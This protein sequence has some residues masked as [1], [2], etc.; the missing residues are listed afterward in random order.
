MP[1]HQRPQRIY[2]KTAPLVGIGTVERLSKSLKA[3]ARCL[4]ALLVLWVGISL[5]SPD[6][7]FYQVERALSYAGPL[8]AMSQHVRSFPETMSSIVQ[9]FFEARAVEV[10]GV[11]INLSRAVNPTFY[12]HDGKLTSQ[13]LQEERAYRVYLPPGY[14]DSDAHYPTLVLLHGMGQDHKWWTEVARIDRI[15]TAMITS[16]KMRPTIIVMPNGNR[17]EGDVATTGLY[18]GNCKT[19][20][21]I[22]ARL[23]KAIG[24]ML[25]RLQLYNVS[26]DGDFE[27]FITREVIHE[28]DTRY[29]TSG[30]R[31]IGGFS[32]GGRG[33]V[34]LA[35]AHPD[36]FQGAFGL[37][38]NYD[39]LRQ[40]LRRG[41]LAFQDGTRLFLGA[42]DHDQRG[43]Y[44]E[45]N[46]FLFH[47]ELLHQGILHAYCI[48]EGAHSD[49]GWISVMPEALEYLLGTGSASSREHEGQG[50]VCQ[51]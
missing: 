1:L 16:G 43:V 9:D 32:L 11:R 14:G 38:G 27:E 49:R 5:F 33:A 35:L 40:S 36:V 30:E 28:V 12:V 24:D 8:G 17:V 23:L 13:V 45:L 10:E 46:T 7:S 18:D 2:S 48:Y 25:P 39:Y 29:R 22:L 3:A 20:L 44:G 50:S 34:Q 19:G 47:Q 41:A 15:A 6:N 21:D 31:Y 4:V 37:S 26:C 51:S 42:G